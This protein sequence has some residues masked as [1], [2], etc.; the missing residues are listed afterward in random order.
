MVNWNNEENRFQI[1]SRDS[2][3]LN[4]NKV[5]RESKLRNFIQFIYNKKRER[6]KYYKDAFK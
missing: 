2:C 4:G 6:N 3:E 5:S 1:I